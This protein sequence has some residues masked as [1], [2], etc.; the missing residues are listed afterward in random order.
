MY[1]EW[2]ANGDPHYMMDVQPY[3]QD[4]EKIFEIY[5]FNVNQASSDRTKTL[6]SKGIL[7]KAAEEIPELKNTQTMLV[8]I[9]L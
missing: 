4:F 8:I 7:R 6:F 2:F 9:Y 5:E 1:K 3:L